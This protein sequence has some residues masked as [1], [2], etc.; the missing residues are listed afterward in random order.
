MSSRSTRLRFDYVRRTDDEQNGQFDI[1]AQI[2]FEDR[3]FRGRTSGY[4]DESDELV[5]AAGAVLQ[6]VEDFV[7]HRFE[8]QTLELDRINTLGKELIVLLINVRFDGRELQIFGSCGVSGNLLEAS[9]RAALDATNR[10]V[11]LSLTD[12]RVGETVLKIP[13]PSDF[14]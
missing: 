9:A 3:I 2:S 8:C 5:L 6:A 12:D 11:E 1:V 14:K 13:P 7:Q 4:A 10:F